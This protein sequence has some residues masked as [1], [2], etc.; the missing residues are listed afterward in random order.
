MVNVGKTYGKYPDIDPM[1][2]GMTPKIDLFPGLKRHVRMLLTQS[3]WKTSHNTPSCWLV[4]NHPGFALGHLNYFQ[5][6]GLKGVRMRLVK[7][8]RM[9]I[10][11]IK[12]LRKLVKRRKLKKLKKKLKRLKKLKVK[13]VKRRNVQRSKLWVSDGVCN[14]WSDSYPGFTGEAGQISWEVKRPKTLNDDVIGMML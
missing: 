4:S 9:M 3:S 1:G 13:R 12:M 11:M 8:R 6:H 5:Q 2:M 14:R 10:K 7:E